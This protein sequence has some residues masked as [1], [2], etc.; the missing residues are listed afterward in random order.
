MLKLILLIFMSAV[1]G[2]TILSL[3]NDGG[4]NP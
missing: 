3:G 2:I 4:K 1:V